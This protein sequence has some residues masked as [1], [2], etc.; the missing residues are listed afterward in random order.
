MRSYTIVEEQ[1]TWKLQQKLVNLLQEHWLEVAKHKDIMVLDPDWEKYRMLQDA[2][3]LF[4]LVLYLGDQPVGYS[5][6]IIDTHLHYSGLTAA[7]NDVLYVHPDHRGTQALRLM[8]E[9]KRVAR[10]RGAKA[11]LWHAKPNTSLD[12]ILRKRAE[13]QDNVYLQPL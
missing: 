13:L 9:T 4:A 10:E 2:G 5:A 11:M 1:L 12:S 7:S 8:N 3:T 6:N